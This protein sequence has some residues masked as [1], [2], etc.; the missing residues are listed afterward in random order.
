MAAFIIRERFYSSFDAHVSYL[1]YIIPS[2]HVNFRQLP[3]APQPLP[4]ATDTSWA[5]W[6]SR[7]ILLSLEA[8][9]SLGLQPNFFQLDELAEEPCG[10]YA[11]ILPWLQPFLSLL[12]LVVFVKVCSYYCMCQDVSFPYLFT[13]WSPVL[14]VVCHTQKTGLFQHETPLAS[15]S[16]DDLL[17]SKYFHK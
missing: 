7:A 17:C 9:P 5:C 12:T 1:W 10:Q 2:L 14:S 15:E 3:P 4:A 16:S 8:L 13:I 6:H 11:I